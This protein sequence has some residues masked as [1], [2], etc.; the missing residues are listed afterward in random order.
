MTGY[1]GEMEAIEDRFKS[2]WGDL[3]PIEFKNAPITKPGDENGGD[4]G[5]WVRFRIHPSSA[6]VASVGGPNVRF[7]HAGDVIVEIFTPLHSGPKSI[8]ELVDAAASIF[9]GWRQDGITFW[10]PRAVEVDAAKG[11]DRMN[12]IAPYQRDESFALQ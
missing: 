4:L 12:V 11:W 8:R 7:R 5:P 2:E 6:V 10:A 1:L 3:T 9:R